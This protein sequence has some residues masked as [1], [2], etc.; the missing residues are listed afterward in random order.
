MAIINKKF[1]SYYG[2]E[3]G[4]QLQ[5]F[6]LLANELL[7]HIFEYVV[8]GN[9]SNLMN[10]EQVCKTWCGILQNKQFLHLSIK[11]ISFGKSDWEEYLGDVGE[12]PPIP[13]GILK[14][15]NLTCPYFP[16]KKVWEIHLLVLV[17]KTVN[18][19]ELTPEYL[20]ELVKNPKNGG[21]PANYSYYPST[22]YKKTPV[23]ESHWV[24]IGRRII[25]N[26]ALKKHSDQLKLLKPNYEPP[27]L[28]D[29]LVAIL[30]HHVKTGER[31]FGNE[32]SSCQ[33]ET[34]LNASNAYPVSIG[35]FTDRGLNVMLNMHAYNVFNATGLGF[36][37]KLD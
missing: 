12:V 17:P 10:C 6:D 16:N 15:L 21:P 30:T 25:P 33:E 27:H 14:I 9:P 11:T 32:R 1:D 3:T 28:T 24:L 18:E 13:K 31:L 8:A 4:N 37:R 26:S 23:S 36:V 29:A 22:A 5:M 19:K 7:M 20:E 34:V 35:P 2:V